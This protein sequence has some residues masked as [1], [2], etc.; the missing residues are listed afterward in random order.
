M[1]KQSTLNCRDFDTGSETKVVIVIRCMTS[2]RPLFSSQS[3][4]F[5]ESQSVGFKGIDKPGRNRRIILRV[6]KADDS[7]R[8]NF[9]H[10]VS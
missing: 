6:M 4:D 9:S 8:L 1:Q 7:R 5:A 3:L 10:P 2:R